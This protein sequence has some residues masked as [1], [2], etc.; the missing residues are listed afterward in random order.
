[1]QKCVPAVRFQLPNFFRVGSNEKKQT[2]ISRILHYHP[3][4]R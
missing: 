1:M 3:L 4:T 2:A